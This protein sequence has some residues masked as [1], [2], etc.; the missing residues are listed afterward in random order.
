MTNTSNLNKCMGDPNA[1]VVVGA[2][3]GTSATTV[4]IGGGGMAKN[5]FAETTSTSTASF[6]DNVYWYN[7]PTK[8]FG[9]VGGTY[10]I[11]LSPADTYSTTDTTRL[12]WNLDNELGGYRAGSAINLNSDSTYRKVIY[13]KTDPMFRIVRDY[14]VSDLTKQGYVT[15]YDAPY[16][17]VTT[18]E[19]LAKC[20]ADPS[21][22]VFVGAK[23]DSYSS[24]FAVGAG[25]VAGN[26]FAATTSTTA[27]VLKN[28]KILNC[29]GTSVKHFNICFHFLHQEC[30]GTTL[31]ARP[32]DL[33]P[34][35]KSSW[36]MLIPMTSPTVSASAGM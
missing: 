31:M 21:K 2:L 35:P 14:Y 19:D 13:I 16:N 23:S 33:L 25:G 20:N 28:G 1:M 17:D 4:K 12:S 15:C 22:K 36:K 7:V 9:F 34:T 30:T 10:S 32:S 3:Y 6:N 26:V 27:A 11:F 8:S 29:L 24:K 5:V 18:Q